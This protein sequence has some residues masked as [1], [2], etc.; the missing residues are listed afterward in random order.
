MRP[1]IPA[2]KQ[3]EMDNKI[4]YIL[5]LAILSCGVLFWQR[6]KRR[7][8]LHKM[9]ENIGYEFHSSRWLPKEYREAKFAALKGNILPRAHNF[10]HKNFGE[11]QLSIF[12]YKTSR[13][14]NDTCFLFSSPSINFPSFELYPNNINNKLNIPIFNTKRFSISQN[15]Q[16]AKKYLLN[17]K[18][19]SAIRAFFNDDL[20]AHLLESEGLVIEGRGNSLLMFYEDIFVTPD[21]ITQ[22]IKNMMKIYKHFWDA[23]KNCL[24]IQ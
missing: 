9:A 1:L 6:L 21:K 12:D 23:T 18:D 10:F 20:I 24:T 8:F 4:I 19:E 3:K 15:P 2:V 13:H 16:F 14:N 17:G 11:Y 7:R 5:I 22:H